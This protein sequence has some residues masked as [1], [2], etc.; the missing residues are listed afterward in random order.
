MLQHMTKNDIYEKLIFLGVKNGYS[1][2][3]EFR[4]NIAPRDLEG[5]QT[6]GKKNI[7]LVWAKRL[8]QGQQVSSWENHWELVA[9]FEVEACDVRNKQGKEFDRHLLDL[10]K[11]KNRD[12]NAKIH[13]F[14]VL[15]TAAYDR[16]WSINRNIEEDIIDRKEWASNS[17]VN[18]IDGRY[19]CCLHEYFDYKNRYF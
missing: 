11:I 4:V 16:K 15:Y 7:D 2:I 3:P 18:V 13:H 19:L 10:P 6:S 9:T 5:K 17:E 8:I 14:I 1:V 12:E